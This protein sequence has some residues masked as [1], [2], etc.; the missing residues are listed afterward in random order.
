[1]YR[2]VYCYLAEPRESVIRIICSMFILVALAIPSL[3]AN[4]LETGIVI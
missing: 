4:N 2:E 1:M 3:I